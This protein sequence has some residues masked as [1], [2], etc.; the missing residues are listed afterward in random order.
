VFLAI[1]HN[2]AKKRPG[3]ARFALALRNDRSIVSGSL[4]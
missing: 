2:D 1:L 3:D 4:L